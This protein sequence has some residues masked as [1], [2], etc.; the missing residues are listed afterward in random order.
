VLNKFFGGDLELY[1][2]LFTD[3]L[4]SNFAFNIDT[5]LVIHSMKIFGFYDPF[6]ILLIASLAFTLISMINYVLGLAC[7]NILVSEKDRAESANSRIRAFRESKYLF[8]ILMLSAAPFYGKFV[9]LFAG[10]CRV[11]F[12]RVIIIS[13]L[14]KLVY[15]IYVI[16]G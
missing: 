6:K 9:V 5:E 11:R 10:F 16:W 13:A 14:S 2:L 12:E 8:L 1:V 15:Y 7:Y 3:S 4:V